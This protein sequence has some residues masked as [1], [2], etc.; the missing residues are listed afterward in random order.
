MTS[1]LYCCKSS[2]LF[3]LKLIAFFGGKW[4][5]EINLKEIDLF[6]VFHFLDGG[7][8]SSQDRN[9][10]LHLYKLVIRHCLTDFQKEDLQMIC[11]LPQC[12]GYFEIGH[13]LLL[14]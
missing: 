6:T 7:N 13:A 5:Q 11:K 4:G 8:I 2:V 3:R 9:F 1:H 12:D 14:H 10:I